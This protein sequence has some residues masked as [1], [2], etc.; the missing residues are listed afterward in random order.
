MRDRRGNNSTF[1]TSSS[2][3]LAKQVITIM[4]ENA[5]K[6]KSKQG[7]SHEQR[8]FYVRTHVHAI[9]ENNCEEC[10]RSSRL[11]IRLEF[12]FGMNESNKTSGGKFEMAYNSGFLQKETN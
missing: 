2:A 3:H 5:S 10:A 8:V 7:T 11:Q 4:K 9:S 6:F 12:E 1:L